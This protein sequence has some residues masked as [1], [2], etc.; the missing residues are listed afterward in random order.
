MPVYP[1]RLKTVELPGQTDV[2][3]PAVPPTAQSCTLIISFLIND[4]PHAL[5]ALT[6]IVFIPLLLFAVAVMLL[7]VVEPVQPTGNVHVYDVA[8]LTGAM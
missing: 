6:A 3:P 7:L 4:D 2:F 1:E 5:L 8:P